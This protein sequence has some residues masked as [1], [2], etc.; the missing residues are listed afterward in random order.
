MKHLHHIVPRHMGGSDDP[1]N[2][3]ELTIEEHAEAHRKLWEEH[4]RWQDKL[5]WDALRGHIACADVIKAAQ[6]AF[7]TPEERMIRSRRMSELRR[8]GK[9]VNKPNINAKTY[10]IIAPDGTE[11]LIKNLS[12][13]SKEKGSI[14]AA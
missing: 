12:K 6:R 1:S 13:W 7:H 11:T 8:S 5:A 4:G 9:C 14:R 2:L 3:I 10:R